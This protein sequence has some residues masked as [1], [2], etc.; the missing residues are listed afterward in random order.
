MNNSEFKRL[1]VFRTS[2][3]D[4]L[5]VHALEAQDETNE[6]LQCYVSR[7]GPIANSH[8]IQHVITDPQP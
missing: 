1:P 3:S 8:Q 4:L 7:G 2:C 5:T 6:A